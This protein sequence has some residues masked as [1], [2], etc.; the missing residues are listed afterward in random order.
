MGRN[1]Y[2]E[3]EW[4]RLRLRERGFEQGSNLPGPLVEGRR[5][6]AFALGR[7]RQCSAPLGAGIIGCASVPAVA[8]GSGLVSTGAPAG[9]P[10]GR[11]R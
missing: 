6:L 7:L 11:S 5:R 3:A 2:E 9:G 1:T 10:V 8:E 4:E